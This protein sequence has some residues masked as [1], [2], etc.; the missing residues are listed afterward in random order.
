MRSLTPN[1]QVRESFVHAQ[2]STHR[3]S[4]AKPSGVIRTIGI[5]GKYIAFFA[6]HFNRDT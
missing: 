4:S 6:N 5:S 1:E 2:M 3:R